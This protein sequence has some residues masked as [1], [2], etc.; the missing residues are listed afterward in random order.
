MSRTAADE[1]EFRVPNHENVARSYIAKFP[2]AALS[3]PFGYLSRMG[4]LEYAVLFVTA[5]VT[6][7][8]S[9]TMGAAGGTAMISI[10]AI[11][12]PPA[13][14]V[15]LH[16]LI[17]L[18]STSTRV[19]AM[20]NYICW[21]LIL[22]FTPTMILGTWIAAQ[23]W[24]GEQMDWFKPVIGTL[25]LL[26]LFLRRFAHR[27]RELPLAIYPLGGIA[28]GFLNIFVGATGLLTTMFYYRDELRKEEIIASAAVTFCWGHFL[29]LP[30]FL[31]LGFDYLSY[32]PLLI[33]MG[34]CVIAGT[35]IGKHLLLHMSMRMFRIAFEI[36]LALLALYLIGSTV[37]K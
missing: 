12:L 4:L 6:A 34:L 18:G 8:I 5:L 2:T 19:L 36:V 20:I 31:A 11:L 3:S 13:A 22:F 25:V 17:Q 32:A 37:Y 14:V 24:S 26:F 30:T 1:I 35:L 23:I 10:M 27:L 29:K 7:A 28:I 21:R 33:G 16:G 9:A 15:P